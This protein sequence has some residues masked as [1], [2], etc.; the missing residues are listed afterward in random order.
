MKKLYFIILLVYLFPSVFAQTYSKNKMVPLTASIDASVPSITLHW[1]E[2]D[3][4]TSYDIYRKTKESD[5][6][7]NTLATGLSATTRS[8]VDTDI[9]IGEEYEYLIQRNF[10][11]SPNVGYGFILCA[12]E[13]P[14]FYNQGI[15]LLVID[16]LTCDSLH[17]EIERWIEDAEAD[18]WAVKTIGVN[19]SD[20]VVDV[21]ASIVSHYWEDAD[22]T[23]TLFFIGRVPVPY[24]GNICPDGHPD[25]QGA[26]PADAYYAEL[27]GNWTDASVNSTSSGKERTI[28]TPG[29]GKFDQSTFPSTVDLQIGRVDMKDLPL[30][31]KSELSLLKQYLDKNHAYKNKL[32]TPLNRGLVRD[33]FTSYAEGFAASA[34]NSFYAI[35]DTQVYNIGYNTVL[36]TNDYQWAYGCGGGTYTSCSGVITSAFLA[37]DTLQNVFNFLFG[38]YF[39]DWDNSSSLL[40]STLAS[41]SLSVAWSGRPYWYVHQMALGYPIG[42]CTKRTM[43]NYNTYLPGAMP[44]GVHMAL[45]GDPT[46]RAHTLSPPSHIVAEFTNNQCNISWSPSNETVLGYAIFKRLEN[47]NTYQLLS[48][49]IISDTTFIDNSASDSGVY[50]YMVRAVKLQITPSG[51]YYNLS[52]GKYDTAYNDKAF[53]AIHDVEKKHPLQLYPNPAQDQLTFDNEQQIISEIRIYDVVGKEV[54]HIIANN[55]KITINISELKRGVYFTEIKTESET[56]TKKFMKE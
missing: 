52:L 22:N 45:L 42:Y 13:R 18:G 43:N 37:T 51:S 20:N 15:L 40:R 48:S 21:K 46:L 4:T 31:S 28:N 30:Y 44:Q 10:S 35:C 6:W 8:Y 49:N 5:T 36:A 33:N 3:S 24:S 16:T 25:H 2:Q 29:D 34:F 27:D 55:T 32:F 9:E 54:K 41:G 39:G 1:L 47:E 17:F 12:I 53:V 38:S 26:W 11:I 56:V 19:P 50:R 23:R 14:F 7:T